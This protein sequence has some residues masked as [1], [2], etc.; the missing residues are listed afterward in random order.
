MALLLGRGCALA[1]LA[2]AGGW[3]LA[4][5]RDAVACGGCFH[6]AAVSTVDTGFVSDH[7]MVF[8]MSPTQT[9]LWDQ[10]RYTGSPADFAWVLPVRPGARI[11]MSHDAWIAALDASTQT[12]ILGPT[13]PV[14]KGASG[15]ASAP[16]EFTSSAPRGG[17][18]GAAGAG[19]DTVSVPSSSED[20]DAASPNPAAPPQETV[21]VVSQRVVGP[22]DSITVR[23]SQGQALG[24]WLRANG[25][26]LPSS[27][28]P[29]VDAYTGAGFDFMALKLAP[30]VGVQAMQP[31]RI[32]TPGADP[33]LPLRMIAAGI[34]AHVGLELYVLS[35]GRYHP[36][37]FPDAIVDFSSLTWDPT[38]ARSNYTELEQQALGAG[39]GTGWLTESAQLANVYTA[40]PQGLG[41][42][43]LYYT[44]CR[45]E[46]YVPSCPPAANADD[47]STNDTGDASPSAAA[48][49]SCGATVVQPCD[50]LSV[51][52]TGMAPD[53]LWVTR[54]HADLPSTA[55]STDLVLEATATQDPV[56]SLHS[57]DR[58]S[59]AGYDP[60]AAVNANANTTPPPL[61]AAPATPAAG[62]ANA[63]CA[64]H[65]I[66]EARGRSPS[67]WM[68]ALAA[69]ALA[70]SRARGRW[71][72]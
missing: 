35:E 48:D 46:V 60:C 23:S 13:P 57:T 70:L 42:D 72:R 7:R 29:M 59:V 14:C 24:D 65:M 38:A 49:A 51:A 41:L 31:V 4:G 17:G 6:G 27:L 39:S 1:A 25:Y 2:V 44:T 54:L 67:E 21:A 61:P 30:S 18:C 3:E 63:A 36:A 10:V 66:D 20:S 47:A 9:V 34:G 58:Y 5:A 11:E 40:G 16:T 33:T 45:T 53:S 37:N 71:V 8:A 64:C 55:L 28:Q 43:A 15:A 52:L 19:V 32:V 62:A 68:V 22:Y 56:P 69:V 50:D 12:V 26:A